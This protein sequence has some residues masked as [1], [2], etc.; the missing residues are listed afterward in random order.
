LSSEGAVEPRQSGHVTDGPKG[1]KVDEL[2]DFVNIVDKDE[3]QYRLLAG[4]LIGT[5]RPAGPY[6]VLILTGEQKQQIAEIES[7]F[8]ARMA[9]KE[10]FLKG[11]IAKA[12]AAV[13]LQRA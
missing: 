2:R 3:D 8:K 7:T 6:I 5:F 9:E 12:Q 4:W 13:K 10:L 11:Q 1:G